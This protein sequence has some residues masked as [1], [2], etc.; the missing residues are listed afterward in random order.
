MYHPRSIQEKHWTLGLS[1]PETNQP[2]LALQTL[3]AHPNPRCV[4]PELEAGSLKRAGPL[5]LLK[6]GGVVV[7]LFTVQV[8]Q[9]ALEARPENGQVWR[10]ESI[11]KPLID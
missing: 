3:R 9:K 10:Q 7:S 5:V 4:R 2:I 11:N 8:S 1:L 6:A